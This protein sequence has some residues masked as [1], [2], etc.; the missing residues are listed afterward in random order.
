MNKI[1]IFQQIIDNSKKIYGIKRNLYKWLEI[2]IVT[3]CV[4][5]NNGGERKFLV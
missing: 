3:K 4:E 2:R 1:D 5:E